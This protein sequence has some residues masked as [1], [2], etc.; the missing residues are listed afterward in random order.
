[1][2]YVAY[3]YVHTHAH[4]HTHFVQPP[5]HFVLQR[6]ALSFTRSPPR[7]PCHSPVIRPHTSHS[8]VS[9]APKPQQR[10]HSPLTPVASCRVLVCL[11]MNL[12]VRPPTRALPVAVSPKRKLRP[13]FDMQQPAP[14]PSLACSSKPQ[15]LIEQIAL[16]L[17]CPLQL[18][19]W[20]YA[21]LSRV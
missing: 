19:S 12:S 18:P 9:T 2:K 21:L 6:R 10:M 7:Q 13:Y 17:A 5:V 16:L 3:T 4:T 8:G 11:R 15:F 14:P 20:L 1:M